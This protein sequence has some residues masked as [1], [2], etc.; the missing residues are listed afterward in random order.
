MLELMGSQV[1]GQGD[2]LQQFALEDFYYLYK[3]HSQFEKKLEEACVIM[4]QR[5]AK[6]V[7]ACIQDI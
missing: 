5:G 4:C 7:A 1:M 6:A 2:Q 3:V